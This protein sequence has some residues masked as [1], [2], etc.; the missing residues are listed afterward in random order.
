MYVAYQQFA[1]DMDVGIDLARE[2]AAARELHQ[3]RR[4]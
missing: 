2:Y 3:S 1:P 4:E